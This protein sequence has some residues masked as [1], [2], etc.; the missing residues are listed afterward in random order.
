MAVKAEVYWK[1]LTQKPE[2]LRRPE[3]FAILVSQNQKRYILSFK[4]TN[5]FTGETL[6]IQFQQ[7]IKQQ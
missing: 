1:Q 2:V 5:V 4:L 6:T 3:K 7:A